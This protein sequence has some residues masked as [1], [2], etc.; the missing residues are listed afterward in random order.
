VHEFPLEIFKEQNQM[1]IAIC[2]PGGSGKDT[3]AAWFRDNTTLEYKHSTSY[4]MREYVFNRMR[5]FNQEIDKSPNYPDYENSEACYYDRARFRKCW[6]SLI[7]KY[8]RDDAARLYKECAAIQDII[9]GIRTKREFLAAQ[10]AGVFQLSI[11]VHRLSG[12]GDETQEYGPEYCDIEIRNE[13]ELTSVYAKL[14]RL[15]MAMWI[16][17]PNKAAQDTV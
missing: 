4:M 1:K 15:A 13:G 3:V 7:D 6:A 14:I 10:K 17:V 16:Y 8:N 5:T 12:D 11:W 2:G 9:T